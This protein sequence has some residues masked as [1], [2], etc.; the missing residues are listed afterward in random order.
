MKIKKVETKVYT[1]HAYC[2]CGGEFTSTNAA[3]QRGTGPTL[4]WHSCDKC[5]KF[6]DLDNIYP[7]LVYEEVEES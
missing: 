5:C 6:V 3:Y 4:Y 2:E 7:R 1:E